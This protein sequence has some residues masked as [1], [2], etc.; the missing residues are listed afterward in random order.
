MTTA[1][2]EPTPEERV[3]DAAAA[4]VA[5]AADNGFIVNITQRPLKP[6]AM[7]HYETTIDVRADR[8]PK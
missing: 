6:L 7:T 1:D 4:L 2:R 8:R 5:Y 3:R